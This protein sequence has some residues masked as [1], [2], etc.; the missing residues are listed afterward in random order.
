M[1]ELSLKWVASIQEIDKIIIGVEDI[2]QLRANL[3]ILKTKAAPE[4]YKKALLLNYD[5]T[6]ILNPSKWEK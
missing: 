5:N 4:L 1:P 2:N 6:K 3:K